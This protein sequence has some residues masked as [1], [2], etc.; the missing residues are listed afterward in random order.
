MVIMTR[1]ER[2]FAGIGN[3]KRPDQTEAVAIDMALNMF[4]EMILDEYTYRLNAGNMHE[5]I[6]ASL[7][8]LGILFEMLS[9]KAPDNKKLLIDRVSNE[10]SY[11]SNNYYELFALYKELSAT[12]NVVCTYSDVSSSALYKSKAQAYIDAISELAPGKKY[13]EQA[14][15]QGAAISIMKSAKDSP[16]IARIGRKDKKELDTQ[17]VLLNIALIELDRLEKELRLTTGFIDTYAEILA[18]TLD[19]LNLS[20]KKRTV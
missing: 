4:R 20:L 11:I 2:I 13:D 14:G 3:A 19:A 15:L 5:D 17:R 18:K 16:N 1:H 6:K 9:K 8:G 12:L 7:A 10:L